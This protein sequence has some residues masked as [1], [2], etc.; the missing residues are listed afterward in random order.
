MVNL[1]TEEKPVYVPAVFLQ[2]DDEGIEAWSD[3]AQGF[4]TLSAEQIAALL[5]E[6]PPPDGERD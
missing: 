6:S 4:I 5:S 2:D 3:L 1:G